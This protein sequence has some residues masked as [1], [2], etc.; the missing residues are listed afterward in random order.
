MVCFHLLTTVVV[1][2]FCQ[3]LPIPDLFCSN[4]ELFKRAIDIKCLWLACCGFCFSR[5]NTESNDISDNLCCVLEVGEIFGDVAKIWPATRPNEWWAGD[6]IF[7]TLGDPW[8]D[9]YRLSGV[10]RRTHTFAITFLGKC[11]DRC[12][13][14]KQQ[15]MQISRDKQRRGANGPMLDKGQERVVEYEGWSISMHSWH[16]TPCI[17]EHRLLILKQGPGVYP[18]NTLYTPV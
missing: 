18:V 4:C 7:G 11:F 2:V 3:Q 8:C 5:N 10:R 16:P 13:D 14:R 17:S 1:C 15:N 6:R 9:W 12:F